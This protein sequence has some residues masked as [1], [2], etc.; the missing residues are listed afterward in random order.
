MTG[1]LVPHAPLLLP[2]VTPKADNLRDIWDALTRV[3]IPAEAAVVV[4][5]PHAPVGTYGVNQGS[6]ADFGIPSVTGKF[7]RA[8]IDLDLPVLSARL[9]HGA[10]VPLLLLDAPNPV[11]VVGGDVAEKVREVARERE[12]F[13]LASAHTSVRLSERA[14]LPYSFAAVRLESRFITGIESDCKVAADLA[15]EMST[16][17][18]SCSAFTLRAFGELFAGSEGRVLAYGSPFGVGYP[19]VTA[20]LDV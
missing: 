3:E 17:G 7:P 9:D 4:L 11:V 18:G 12:T 6:L 13:V 1:A 16:V 5:T 2:Q 19:V 10:L 20:E 8:E 14:P 15:D